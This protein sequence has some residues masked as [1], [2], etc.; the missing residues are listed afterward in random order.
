MSDFKVEQIDHV[1]VYVS[2]QH[3]AA[4]WYERVLGLKVLDE[5]ANLDAGGPLVVSSDGGSTSL[6]LFKKQADE[7]YLMKATTVAFRVE[8]RGFLN[9]L[10]RLG[11]HEAPDAVGPR[12]TRED[13]IDHGYCFSVYFSDPDGNPYEVTTYDYEDVRARLGGGES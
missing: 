7:A 9:F 13:V 10:T 5:S 4:R 11:D 12:F 2:D 8:G 3:E 1:H 6:A